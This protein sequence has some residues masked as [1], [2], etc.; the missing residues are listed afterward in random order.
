MFTLLVGSLSG[1]GIILFELNDPFRGPYRITPSTS[2]L[3]AVRAYLD[4]SLCAEVQEH[5]GA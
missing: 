4:E 5:D 1:I 2:H 3:V